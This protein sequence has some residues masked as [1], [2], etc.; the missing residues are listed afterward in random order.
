MFSMKPI[1][2]LGGGQLAR[3][4]VLEAHRLNLPVAVL[5]PLETDPARAV[6]G[7][8]VQGDPLNLKDLTAFMKLCSTVTFESEFFDADLISKAM[9]ESKTPVWPDPKV[10]GLLQ[11]R[12]SQKNLLDEYD[13]PTATWRPVD[14][15]QDAVVAYVALDGKVVFKKRRGGYDGYGTFVVKNDGDL[16]LFANNGVKEPFI[17][18]K[19]I[20]FSREIAI[21]AVRDQAGAVFF[22]PFVESHQKHARCLFVKGPLRETRTFIEMKKKIAKFLS[23]I[24]YV[25]A[26][27]IEMFE[28]PKGLIVNEIAPRVHNTGH[29]T[30]DAFSLSQFSLHLRAVAGL[31]TQGF[32]I[33]RSKAFAMWNLLGSA[34]SKKPAQ[35]APWLAK[36][37]VGEKASNEATVHWY[38]KFESRPG[39]KMGHVNAQAQTPDSALKLA[40]SVAAQ[41]A[42]DIGY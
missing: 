17:A 15:S 4:L 16:G 12:L 6:T 5:S 31:R 27:G 8:W 28:T 37:A 29:Y 22:Y 33:P 9:K 24:G 1:G 25:G 36:P 2:I 20:K 21:I 14:S 10:M 3:M 35:L 23:G 13:I 39:R 11:D 26:M 40:K 30:I 34:K 42:K 41:T 38:G 32:A 19:W 7:T 18:E